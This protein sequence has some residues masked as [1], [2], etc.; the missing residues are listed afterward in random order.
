M[1]AI[2]QKKV[3]RNG[4]AITQNGLRSRRSLSF[5]RCVDCPG[6]GKRAFVARQ[7]SR[8][9]AKR[10]SPSRRVQRL[11]RD[12]RSSRTRREQ[13]RLSVSPLRLQ[14]R[15]KCPRALRRWGANT[16]RIT[17]CPEPYSPPPGHRNKKSG[18]S[19][20][21]HRRT[22]PEIDADSRSESKPGGRRSPSPTGTAPPVSALP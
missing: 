15:L 10:R 16:R 19:A 4:N 17:R 6:L 22:L 11:A 12:S 3:M 8:R 1:L 21:P 2:Y 9:P 13:L 20:R 7:V 5:S 18:P 14:A